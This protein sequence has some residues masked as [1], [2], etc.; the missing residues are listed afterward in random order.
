[1]HIYGAENFRIFALM[2]LVPVELPFGKSAMTRTIFCI[3]ACCSDNRYQIRSFS[4]SGVLVEHPNNFDVIA[5][6]L[7][8]KTVL[9]L[10]A[11]LVAAMVLQ[12]S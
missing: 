2:L 7:L 4:G 8:L 12:S 10:F 11:E 9:I 5:E 3:V 6:I 1:M